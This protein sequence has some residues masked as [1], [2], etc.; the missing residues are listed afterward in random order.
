MTFKK[1]FRT[2]I[3]AYLREYASQFPGNEWYSQCKD[4]TFDQKVGMEREMSEKRTCG[5]NEAIIN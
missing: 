4:R 5:Y 3:R 2:L 1:N